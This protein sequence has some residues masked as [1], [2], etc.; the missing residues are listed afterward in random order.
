MFNN[1]FC[2]LVNVILTVWNC[3]VFQ[4]ISDLMESSTV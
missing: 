4:V 3:F 1:D 2:D